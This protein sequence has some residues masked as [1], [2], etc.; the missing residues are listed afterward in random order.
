MNLAEYNR[1]YHPV[2]ARGY[3]YARPEP[4]IQWQKVPGHVISRGKGIVLA[5]ILAGATLPPPYATW[6]AALGGIYW[7]FVL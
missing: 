2:P 4:T 7:L 3:A 5:S 1:V 6:A